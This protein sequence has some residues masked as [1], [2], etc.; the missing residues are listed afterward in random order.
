MLVVSLT[1]LAAVLLRDDSTAEACAVVPSTG[2]AAPQLVDRDQ[3]LPAGSEGDRRREVV[4]AVEGLGGPVGTVLT[5]RFFERSSQLPSVVPYADRLALV[6]T[7]APGRAVVQ[8]V[9]PQTAGTDWRVD[10]AGDPAWTTFTGGPVGEDLV[11]AFSGPEPTLL[12]LA[13]DSAPLHCG[14]LARA[15]AA[16]GRPVQVRTDQAGRDVV[17]AGVA[18]R[19]E[20]A[21]RVVRLVDPVTGEVRWSRSSRGPLASVTVAGDLVL[22]ARADSSTVATDGLP[23]PGSGSPSGPWL[24]ALSREDGSPAWSLPGAQVLLTAGRDGT[25]YLLDGRSR[26]SAVGADGTTRWTT[27]VPRGLTSASVWGDRLVLR[28]P[29]PR[30]GTLLRAYATGTGAPAWTV[31]G[32]QAPPVGDAPRSGLGAPLVEDG[33]AWVPA[34]NGLLEVDVATGRVTR[35]DSTARVDQLLRVGPDVVVVSATALLATS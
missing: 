10:L 34:P 15:G 28:G 4:D 3:L 22:L 19:G 21:R 27:T 29:D 25:S 33:T 9:D 2:E 20:G 13:A 17:V 8:A 18:G 23:R 32:R 24:E 11:L 31:R 6:T 14:P 5:G 1:G 26:L 35:H 12:T 16:A 7:P 30:G